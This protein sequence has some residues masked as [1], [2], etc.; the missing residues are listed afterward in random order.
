VA[1]RIGHPE[2]G[3]VTVTT[4]NRYGDGS[5][6]VLKGEFTRPGSDKIPDARTVILSH[7]R[8]TQAVRAAGLA[9]PGAE[10]SDGGGPV[11]LLLGVDRSRSRPAFVIVSDG[12][13][14]GEPGAGTVKS[15]LT[16]VRSDWM[17]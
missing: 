11:R 13:P 17:N 2:P 6:E 5:N 14:E 7:Q 1:L 9:I 3:Q 10:G 4:R 12:I 16:Q 15:V 8:L